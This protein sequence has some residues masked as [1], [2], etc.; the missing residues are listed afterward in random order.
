MV[1]KGFSRVEGSSDWMLVSRLRSGSDPTFDT[2]ETAGSD[3]ESVAE[4]GDGVDA[5][6][7]GDVCRGRVLGASATVSD[8]EGVVTGAETETGGRLD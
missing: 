7:S 2:V 3:R 4:T 5:K 1:G 8:R 6:L